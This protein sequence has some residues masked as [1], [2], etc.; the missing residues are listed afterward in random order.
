MTVVNIRAGLLAWY[1]R[2]GYRLTGEREP[3]PYDD[4]RIGVPNRDDLVFV[5]LVEQLL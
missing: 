5:V 4:D 1:Q 2:R 3:F